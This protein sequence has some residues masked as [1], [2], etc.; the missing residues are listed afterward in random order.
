M[1][2]R[3]PDHGAVGGDVETSDEAAGTDLERLPRCIGHGVD[4]GHAAVTITRQIPGRRQVIAYEGDVGRLGSVSDR[5]RAAGGVAQERDLRVGAVTDVGEID[6]IGARQARN[7]TRE[8]LRVI[9]R[10]RAGGPGEDD[11]LGTRAFDRSR[12]PVRNRDRRFGRRRALRP[13]LGSRIHGSKPTIHSRPA[14]SRYCV[15]FNQAVHGE[16]CRRSVD[17]A[18]PFRPARAAESS[19][20]QIRRLVGDQKPAEAVIPLSAQPRHRICKDLIVPSRWVELVCEVVHRAF[21]KMASRL[22]AK[23]K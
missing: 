7:L 19:I 15:V 4:D 22:L 5:Q 13:T 18:A 9:E 2:V 8:T 21:D 10:E 17:L 12:A 16:F 11:G 3:A 1:R 20:A 6:G 23:T 14:M